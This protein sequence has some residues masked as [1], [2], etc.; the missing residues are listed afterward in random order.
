MNHSLSLLF[1][2]SVHNPCA[3]KLNKKKDNERFTA[4]N[5][6]INYNTRRY[7]IILCYRVIL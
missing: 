2:R 3:L 1:N 5:N 6:K 4:L 7:I